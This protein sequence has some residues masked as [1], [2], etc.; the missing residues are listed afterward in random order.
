MIART[1]VSLV[2][3]LTLFFVAVI[4]SQPAGLEATPTP[5]TPTLSDLQD[6]DQLQQLFN[7][8]AGKPRL[9][10]LISPT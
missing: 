8:R 9:V 10:L 7:E 4:G 2:A 5:S 6:I 1:M 3:A